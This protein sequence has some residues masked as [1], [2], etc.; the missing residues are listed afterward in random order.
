MRIANLPQ[1]QRNPATATPPQ[2]T[3]PPRTPDAPA[4]ANPP[5]VNVT[6]ETTAAGG[7]R[8]KMSFEF[9]MS[10]D[11][12][13][14]NGLDGKATHS[15][16]GSGVLSDPTKPATDSSSATGGLVKDPAGFPAGSVR[17]PGGYTVVPRGKDA[18]WDIYKP[19][20]KADEKPMTK[21]WGDPHVDEGD[22][23][24]WD[25]TKTSTFRLPDGTAIGVN[26]TSETGQSVSRKLD[27]VNG[28]DHV[29]I[30]GINTASPTTSNVTP[31]GE[32]MMEELSARNDQFVLGN[33]DA[34]EDVRWLRARNGEIEGL[35]TGATQDAE[36]TYDQ[37][38][39]KSEETGAPFQVDQNGLQGEPGSDQ[40]SQQL[41]QM[42][43]Q[44]FQ[45]LF[46]NL[47]GGAANDAPA[48]EQTVDAAPGAN[49]TRGTNA[50]AGADDVNA[51]TDVNQSGDAMQ[52]PDVNTDMMGTIEGLQQMLDVVKRLFQL[53][54]QLG[55]L[56]Q[57]GR[58]NTLAA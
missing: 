39:A 52:Q 49:A 29:S 36:K 53:F 45:G 22:G 32:R 37:T 11:L 6:R 50:L 57:G 8:A 51:A 38:I 44:L 12:N 58:R 5:A 30:D 33:G 9:S 25:F 42:L 4:V 28:D 56:S 46:G 48:A 54:S 41:M 35:I 23:T 19:G 24:R 10:F 40:F 13:S 3:T 17:T 2:G 47:L 16:P 27:I 55:S 34:Q 14:L 43:T 18:Q 26:T 15:K 20:Q 31:G 1:T 7:V 21:V